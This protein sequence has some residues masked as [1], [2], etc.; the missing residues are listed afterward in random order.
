MDEADVARMLEAMRAQ[1]ERDEAAGELAGI[2]LDDLAAAISH[3]KAP[4]VIGEI[5]AIEAGCVQE[6]DSAPDF[7]LPWL[8][9][10][11]A[12]AGERFTLSSH[13]GARPVALIFGSY[14]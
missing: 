4:E 11:P 6:G 5:M 12:G 1:L 2:G 13:F 8:G 3:P 7:T 9:P 10:P 14:T